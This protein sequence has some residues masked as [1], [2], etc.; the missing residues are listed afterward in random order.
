MKVVF[1]QTVKKV[2]QK[3]VVKEVADGY[4]RNFL[5]PHGLAKPAT[6]EALQELKAE[7]ERRKREAEEDLARVERIADSLDGYELEITVKI[8]P[9][10]TFY[11]GL[12]VKRISEE[13]KKR[14]FSIAPEQISF[15]TDG[16]IKEPG[17]YEAVINFDHGLEAE[18]KIMV[19]GKEE[20]L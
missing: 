1:L 13:L 10:G 12:A 15:K 2:A 20:T 14:G 6:A 5:I 9:A 11:G 4:A 17:A 16:P 3:G 7:A 8:S 19:E 18:I